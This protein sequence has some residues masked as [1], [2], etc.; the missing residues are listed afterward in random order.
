MDFQTFFFALIVILLVAA[1]YSTQG[2]KNKLLV[3]YTRRDRTE[4]D[5]WVKLTDNY[6]ILDNK[7]FDVLPNKITSMWH[8]KG[9]NWLFPTRVNYIKFSW[10]SRFPHDPD[11]YNITV[12][13]PAVRN[14][15]NK[16]ETFLSYARSFQ[17]QTKKKAGLTQYLP[18]ITL[19]LVIAVAAYFYV[20]MDELGRQ[21]FN[22]QQSFNAIT[23]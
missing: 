4:F 7:K 17:P 18:M 15:I 13:D 2:K 3:H 9:I 5:K 10:Y 11:N 1:V 19:I 14:A 21:M 6:V 22:L 12:I 16:S 23:K 20:N 8:T